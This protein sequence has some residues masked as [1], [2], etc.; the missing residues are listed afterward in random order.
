MMAQNRQIVESNQQLITVIG[1]QGKEKA[2]P[3]DFLGALGDESKLEDLSRSDYAQLIVNTARN[4]IKENVIAKLDLGKQV[5]EIGGATRGLIVKNQVDT[6]ASKYKD[7]W[8]WGNEIQEEAKLNPML[9]PE[10]SYHLA[11][12]ANPAK[13]K[14]VDEK[15]LAEAKEAGAPKQPFGGFAPTNVPLKTD[16][17]NMDVTEAAETAY[18]EIMDALSVGEAE[19]SPLY[20]GVNDGVSNPDGD[21]G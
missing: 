9:T 17:Q 6:A 11:R 3:T 1:E 2:A 15:L 12:A 5:E 16:R 21:T 19:T 20:S 13:A 14:E 4:E 7:F 8:Q 10:Q 18:E